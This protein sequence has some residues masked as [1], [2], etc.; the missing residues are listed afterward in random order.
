MSLPVIGK[1][2][3]HTKSATTERY[4]HLAADPLKA[5]NEAIGQQLAKLLGSGKSTNAVLDLSEFK[6]SAV[7]TAS[8][9]VGKVLLRNR[10]RRRWPHPQSSIR[11]LAAM[12][13]PNDEKSRNQFF[14]AFT[15]RY[16]RIEETVPGGLESDGSLVVAGRRI[17][18]RDLGAEMLDQVD[19]DIQ[20]AQEGWRNTGDLLLT[21]TRIDATADPAIRRGASINKAK[22]LI[23]DSS[24]GANRQR[25]EKD[26]SK[27]RD[28]AH[29]AAAASL[30][31]AI[32]VHQTGNTEDIKI[33]TPVFA[34][35]GTVICYGRLFEQFGLEF[36]PW[37]RKDPILSPESTWRIASPD[38][39]PWPNFTPSPLNSKEIEVLRAFRAG[40][41]QK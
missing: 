7:P 39:F 22:V 8:S 37:G 33:L 35:L 31:V 32:G 38:Q 12:V 40:R 25:L 30:L 6:G 20:A 13:W 36:I 14:D 10:Y 16:G 23:E 29:L 2:L 9:E 26:L 3:G 27:Y 24:G 4:S 18:L 34:D 17:Q 15:A 21:L 41:G 19:P 1:L 28:V 11:I 5:A